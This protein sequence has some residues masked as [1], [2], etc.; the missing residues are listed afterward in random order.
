M[1]RPT[2]GGFS[3]LFICFKRLSYKKKLLIHT[4][5]VQIIVWNPRGLH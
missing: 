4:L 2:N 3:L 1:E 5:N